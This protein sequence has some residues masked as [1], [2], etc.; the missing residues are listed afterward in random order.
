[1]PSGKYELTASLDLS[2]VFGIITS[3]HEVDLKVPGPEILDE[4]LKSLESPDA[5]IRTQALYQL[6][7]FKQ[8]AERVVVALAA[9]MKDESEGVRSAAMSVFMAYPEHAKK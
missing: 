3:R 5:N 6:R 1:M 9:A 7:Y 2:P 4:H 8:D